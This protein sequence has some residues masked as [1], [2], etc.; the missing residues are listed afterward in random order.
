MRAAAERAAGWPLTRPGRAKG[1]AQ[2]CDATPFSQRFRPTVSPLMIPLI[3]CHITPTGKPP[4]LAV[5]YLLELC[6]ATGIKREETV[7]T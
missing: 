2:R 5:A 7:G 4:P 3:Y 6:E 1:W